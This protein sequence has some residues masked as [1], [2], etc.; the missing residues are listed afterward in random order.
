MRGP[1]HAATD[2]SATKGSVGPRG[3]EEVE[4][5]AEVKE[6]RRGQ[7]GLGQGLARRDVQGWSGEGVPATPLTA[8]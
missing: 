8:V 4:K 5:M 6:R 3:S 2:P 1:E 7:A